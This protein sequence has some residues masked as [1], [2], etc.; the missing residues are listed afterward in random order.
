MKEREESVATKT[1]ISLVAGV[2]AL[3]LI[4]VSFIFFLLFLFIINDYMAH[5]GGWGGVPGYGL[6]QIF[7]IVILFFAIIASAV[8]IAMRVRPS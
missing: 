2:I 3:I 6:T 5:H 8:A 4:I 1:K 7:G